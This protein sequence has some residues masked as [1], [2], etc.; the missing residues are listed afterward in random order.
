MSSAAPL[1]GATLDDI[2]GFITRGYGHLRHSAYLFVAMRN[3]QAGRRWLTCIAPLITS[4]KAWPVDDRGMPVK[5]AAAINLALTAEGL[6]ACGLPK[7]VLCTFAPEFMEGMASAQRAHILG[8]S[9]GSAADYWE[10]GGPRNEPLHA[11]VIIHAR[12][13]ATLDSVCAAQRALLVTTPDG[14]IREVKNGLQRGYRP[15]SDC[16]P[17]GFRDAIAQPAIR[18]LHGTDGAAAGATD[19]AVA[20]GEFILGHEN[21]YGLIAPAPVAPGELDPHALLPP[22]ANPYHAGRNLHDFGR[23]G[24]YLV[25]RKLRQ[26][27]AGFWRFMREESIRA[28]GSADP[29]HMIW[30][31][32][33]C[34]GRWPG[35]AP[36]TLAPHADDARLAQRNDFLYERD[37]EG[38][39]CPLGAHVRRSNPR[40]VLNPY[41]VAQSRSMT[42]AHRILRRGRVFGPPLFDPYL[43]QRTPTAAERQTLLALQDDGQARGIHFLCVNASIKSQFEF[44]QQNWC[45]NP[46]FGGLYD[47]KDPLI[48]SVAAGEAASTMSIPGQP[49]GTRTQALPRFVSV[50]AGAY[51][52]MP[53]LPALRFLAALDA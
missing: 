53:S 45:N 9:G 42:E 50:S 12:D 52:F 28:S 13:P 14:G 47:N 20:A 2:Q 17:F 24:S 48:G 19:N 27:V 49:V 36:L 21:H 40:D 32:A 3:A 8:D 26:D 16:E 11:V 34:V 4:A 18:G 29:A 44:I 1:S 35:G 37:R 51:L 5:P 46:R 6:A 23:N 30:L 39:G 7:A 15:E 43:L 41:P 22:S 33:K 10:L 25:Y 31:A 38:Y